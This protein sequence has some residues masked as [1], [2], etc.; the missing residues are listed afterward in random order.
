MRVNIISCNSDWHAEHGRKRRAGQVALKAMRLFMEAGGKMD[1]ID[2]LKAAAIDPALGKLFARGWEDTIGVEAGD[3]TKELL[4]DAVQLVHPDRHPPERKELAERVTGELLALRPFVFPAPKKPEPKPRTG[5][6]SAKTDGDGFAD[7]YQ[8]AVAKTYPCE[9]CVGALW[10]DY[11]A[12]CRGIWDEEQHR[13]A[14]GEK[15]ERE[16]KA[17][18]QRGLQGQHRKA[19]QRSRGDG[20]VECPECRESFEPKRQDA[21]YCSVRC[22]QAAHRKRGGVE[23]AAGGGRLQAGGRGG[24]RGDLPG[25]AGQCLHHDRPV[26]EGAGEVE[27][28]RAEAPGVGAAGGAGCV[29]EAWA[30]AA[31]VLRASAA[32]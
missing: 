26:R 25:R 15:K 10:M 20:K 2:S 12:R 17:A 27:Q 5:N 19:R 7:A 30:G 3:L 13:R 4:D 6:G 31:G 14:E 32:A 9:L 24:N 28:G 22:R 29:R 21:L 8:K 16:R 1:E 11:C 18:R 23:A